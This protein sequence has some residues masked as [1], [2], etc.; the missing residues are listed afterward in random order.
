MANRKGEAHAA[1]IMDALATSERPLT[2][3]ALLDHLRPTGVA[4]PLTVYRALDKLVKSGKVHRIESLNA[5]VACKGSAHHDHI[6]DHPHDHAVAFTICDA[7]GVVDEF[8]DP[9]LCDQISAGLSTRGF[10][11]RSVALEAH[12]LCL[13]CRAKA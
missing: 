8:A 2:A 10:L 5:F 13:S 1:N 4:A 7:C 12:G 6:H 11:P 9:R 3:Y